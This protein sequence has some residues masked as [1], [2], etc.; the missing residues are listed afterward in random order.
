MKGPID[1]W[2]D[3]CGAPRGKPCKVVDGVTIPPA[4]LAAGRAF[5]RARYRRAN[6]QPAEERAAEEVGQRE[7]TPEGWRRVAD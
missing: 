7:H 3:L 2:C 6:A 1:H 4:D 5:H